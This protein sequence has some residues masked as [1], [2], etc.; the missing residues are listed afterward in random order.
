MLDEY[1][2]VPDVFDP[3]AYSNTVLID[4]LLPHL[5][6]PL[7][8]E[9]LVRDLA[10]GGWSRYCMDNSNSLHRLCME[11][12]RKLDQRNRLRKLP[13]MRPTCPITANEWC[14]EGI[15]SAANRPLKGIIAAHVTKEAAAFKSAPQ[16]ASIE[17]LTSTN[18]WPRS[19]SITLDRKI[20]DYQRVLEP[21]FS[22]ARSLMFIDPNLDPSQTNYRTFHSLFGAPFQRDPKPKIE[23]HRSFC[24][25][26]G[27]ARTFPTPG[28]W[29]EAFAGLG[30]SLQRRGLSAEVFGWEDFHDRYLISDIVGLSVPAGFDANNMANDLTTWTRLGREDKDRWQR[31]FDPAARGT[32]LKWHFIIGAA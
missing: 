30:Q 16:V 10:D 26:D 11:F 23:I 4:H 22:Q 15:S 17:K 18:W 19:P 25:G 5:R 12:L 21:V 27:P 20:P 32:S 2:L 13:Q 3:A 29:R 31:Q 7:M 1:V 14:E 24:R 8:Q 6:E 9:A 28:E